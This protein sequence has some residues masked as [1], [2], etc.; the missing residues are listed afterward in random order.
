MM[1]EYENSISHCSLG[2]EHKHMKIKMPTATIQKILIFIKYLC[3]SVSVYGCGNTNL[4]FPAI[5]L[6][7]SIGRPKMPTKSYKVHI[8]IFLL[9]FCMAANVA[10]AA[11]YEK[12]SLALSLWLFAPHSKHGWMAMKAWENMNQEKL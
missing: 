8:N 5:L 11:N 12:T 10:N 1:W 6:L 4:L 7:L 9:S 3:E 2:C